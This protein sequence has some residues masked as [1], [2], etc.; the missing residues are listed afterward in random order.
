[1]TLSCF[2]LRGSFFFFS[3]SVFGLYHQQSP[4]RFILLVH[5]PP[6]I[7]FSTAA[8]R[9]CGEHVHWP[10]QSTVKGLQ[11]AWHDVLEQSSAWAAGRHAVEPQQM[12]GTQSELCKHSADPLTLSQHSTRSKA[13]ATTTEKQPNENKGKGARLLLSDISWFV[14]ACLLCLCECNDCK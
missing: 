9:F 6:S 1:M 2:A 3:I 7:V 11:G 4:L 14:V 13:T 8:H 10:P 5:F 12:A